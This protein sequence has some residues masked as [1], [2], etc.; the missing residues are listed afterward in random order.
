M[1]TRPLLALLTGIAL[2]ATGAVAAPAAVAALPATGTD[3]AGT[4]AVATDVTTSATT[5]ATSAVRV[6]AGGGALVDAAGRT[7]AADAGAVGGRAS[8]QT[9]GDVA[10]TTEDALYRQLRVG[11][12]GYALKVPAA[13]TYRVTLHMQ[14]NYHTAVGARVFSARAEGTTV[15][16]DLDLV[17]TA[18]PRTAY[19]VSKDVAVTDGTLDLAFS[20]RTNLST[21]S[22]IEAVLSSPTTGT[23]GP[24][25]S[26]TPLPSPT[27]PAPTGPVAFPVRASADGTALVDAQGA[28]FTYLADTPWLAPTKLDQAGMRTLL[29]TRRAQGFTAVQMSVLHFFGQQSQS[30]KNAYGDLPFVGGYDL[31]R[32]LEVGA[33]T[34]NPAS[35]DY[36]Y[37][38][39]IAWVVEQ[40]QARGLAITLVPS[41]YGYDGQ[42]W[43]PRVNTTNAKVYGTFLGQRL[44]H[45]GNIVWMLG[46]DNNPV[47]D[48][49]KVSTTADRSDKVAAT[50]AMAYAIRAAEPVRHLMTYHAAR[51]VSSHVHFAGRSWHTLASAYANEYTHKWAVASSGKGIPVVVTE[52]YYDNRPKAPVLDHRKLRAEAWW[53]VLSGAG[54]AYGHENV[55]DVDGA[56]STG[57]RDGSASDI[58]RIR[59]ILA[60]FG[61]VKASRTVLTSG[62]GTTNGLDA[63]VTGRAGSTAVTYVPTSRSVTVDLDALG[64]SQVQ[65][66]WVDP[67]TGTTRTVGTVPAQ[68]TKTLSWPGW[69]DAVL[70]MTAR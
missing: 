16:T 17:R 57:I 30:T 28:P 3:A 13:G 60:P 26:P 20:A 66:V 45:Y 47:G 7:W 40:A 4:D 12:T 24:S 42:D 10:G 22:A 39:H 53:S 69:S 8:T 68:G 1:L 15:F 14:E 25:P 38:D 56:W 48:V 34:S 46:G 67:A 52:A 55:W 63:A 62:A 64:G 9:D 35:P 65:L 61:P 29:D 44:G 32:P 51:T 37:W 58:G 36:D 2:T 59:T 54:F 27:T 21:V 70:L 50:D 18:G 43:R 11:M 5:A 41:W 23:V 33:R 19:A 49:E 6:N 31:A